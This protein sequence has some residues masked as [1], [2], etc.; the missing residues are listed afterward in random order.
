M[1]S[2]SRNF[3]SLVEMIEVDEHFLR[4]LDNKDDI[5]GKTDQPWSSSI[6]EYEG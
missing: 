2:K 5:Q 6:E 1:K 4:Y 3:S